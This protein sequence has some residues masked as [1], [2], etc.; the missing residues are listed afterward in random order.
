MS[1]LMR[2]QF[3]TFPQLHQ[4]KQL[5]CLEWNNKISLPHWPFWTRFL[6]KQK[7]IHFWATKWAFAKQD[8]FPQILFLQSC[9][10]IL[11]TTFQ[12][13]FFGHFVHV[14]YSFYITNPESLWHSLLLQGFSIFLTSLPLCSCYKKN[15]SK[16]VPHSPQKLLTIRISIADDNERQGQNGNR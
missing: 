5:C 16:F 6:P 11:Y 4:Y 9:Q 13:R 15:W 7:N 14:R 3:S 2:I 1:L 10:Y 8:T 12:K